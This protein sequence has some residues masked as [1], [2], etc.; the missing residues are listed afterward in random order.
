[1][2]ISFPPLITLLKS[3]ALTALIILK[4]MNSMNILIELFTTSF[5]CIYNWIR[6]T[7]STSIS[8]SKSWLCI[9]LFP[10][11]SHHCSPFVIWFLVSICS[12]MS[13]RMLSITLVA[14]NLMCVFPNSI[15]SVDLHSALQMWKKL[16]HII[17]DKAPHRQFILNCPHLICIIPPTILCARFSK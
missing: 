5:K 12:Y 17:T 1:M 2:R 4:S 13:L 6:E 14:E 15:C 7:H 3:P 16:L 8:L 11:W 9:F 10:E